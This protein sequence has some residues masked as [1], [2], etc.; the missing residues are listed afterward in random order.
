MV[1]AGGYRV[2]TVTRGNG[3][4]A[5]VFVN[6]GF[7]AA[8]EGW[9]QVQ[10]KVGQFTRT[11]AYDRGGT[12]KS[13]AAPLPRDSAHIALELHSLLK[14]AGIKTPCVLVGASL[15]GIHV[16]VFAH[17]Y[18]GDVAGIVLVDPTPEDLNTRLQAQEPVVWQGIEREM[19]DLQREIGSNGQ[20]SQS[21]LENLNA[22]LQQARDAWPLPA[23]PL[24]LLTATRADSAAGTRVAAIKL[25]LHRE[26]LERVPGSK[27]IVTGNSRHNMSADEPDLVVASIR[28]MVETQRGK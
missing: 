28:E 18:P 24:T 2:R 20:G 26:F 19:P 14:H 23:V 21:E 12:Y 3:A 17:L 10:L 25:E 13:E 9:T 5:V 11:L 16:R 15:G 8:L 27:Q 1:D 4:P 6:G 7:G 22:D